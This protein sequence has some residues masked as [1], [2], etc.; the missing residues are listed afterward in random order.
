M[1]KGIV[2]RL[3]GAVPLECTKI[4]NYSEYCKGKLKHGAADI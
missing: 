4:L 2:A 1:C 3:P